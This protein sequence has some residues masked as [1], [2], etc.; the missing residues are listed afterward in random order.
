MNNTVIINITGVT[1]VW[2]S[3]SI[4]EAALSF[5]IILKC[6]YEKIDKLM[7]NKMDEGQLEN[8]CLSF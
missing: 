6:Q 4:Y 2:S 1:G 3:C 7:Y 5:G 8:P